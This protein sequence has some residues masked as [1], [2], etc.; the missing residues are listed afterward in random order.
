M[1]EMEGGRGGSFTLI[2]DFTLVIMTSIIFI[3]VTKF[4]QVENTI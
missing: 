2:T 4:N 3:V 1:R